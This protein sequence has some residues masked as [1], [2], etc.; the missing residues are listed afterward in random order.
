MA[1]PNEIKNI[2]KA[3]AKYDN[4]YIDYSITNFLSEFDVFMKEIRDKKSMILLTTTP[5]AI[6]IMGQSST[7]QRTIH[8]A[9]TK[10]FDQC[11]SYAIHRDINPILIKSF[12]DM[13]VIFSK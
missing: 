9:K 11:I 3:M 13:Y 7:Y 2:N 4:N 12:K 1:T 8:V 5:Q 6:F 10:Y